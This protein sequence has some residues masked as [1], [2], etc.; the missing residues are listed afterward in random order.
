MQGVAA[1]LAY[2]G[3]TASIGFAH[4]PFVRVDAETSGDRIAG[5][6][7]EE[8]LALRKAIDMAS[9][10]IAELAAIAGGEA[11]QILEF[12]VALLEDEDFIEEILAAISEGDAAD[13]AWRST[14][15]AQIADYNSAEDEY[16][17]ARSSDLADLRDRVTTI[18]RGGGA[19][20]L[21]IPSGAVVCADDLPPSRFLEIDWSGG[22]GLAL[23]RGSPT[24]HVAMLARARG[25]PMVVQL[26]AVPELGATALLDGEGA[27]LEL[28][29]SAEQL[30]LFERRRDN[31]RKSRASARAI[32]RRPTTLWRGER[33][34]LLIN[35]QH[36]D[37]LAHA[38]AQY[39]DGIGLMRTEF[40]LTGRGGL[41]D[42]DAQFAAYDAVLRWAGQRPVTIRTFDAGGDKPVPGF[43]I[44]GEANPFLGVRGLRLCLARPE[45]FT[46][47][48]RAL[49]RAA[50]RGN[51]KVM[52][53]MVTS[54]EELEA[55]RKLFADTVQRLQAEGIAAMLPELG[56]MVEV[57]AA[58]LA[59]N[60]FKA[61]FFSIGSNDLA[62]YVLACDRSNGALAPLMDPLHPAV[63]ELIARTADQGRRA[64]ISVSLCGDMAS[65][66]RCLPALLNCGLRELSVTTSALA[67][68][69]Q[70]IDRLSSGGN[71]G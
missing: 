2:R 23:L 55:G 46:V 7:V 13:V 18:L 28:D 39:A 42:E 14:L 60:S 12:Q 6:L 37:D 67:Q 47:Q 22:G 11:A 70:T 71:L 25:I 9:G 68:I 20:A 45:I 44:D 59:V 52:F 40:L 66:S 69:K 24:S 41:P 50:V 64:G 30:R 31:H 32:L 21:A 53:P 43:T 4:G 5:S 57:P 26:G 1:A 63:L 62:Q 48:L 49:A 10:Q 33:I 54:A 29:P 36:V 15:D 27:T 17:K 51:L 35:I 19:Q 61:A 65:D 56:I 3:R 58:A 38:D 34:K 16:L 8:A